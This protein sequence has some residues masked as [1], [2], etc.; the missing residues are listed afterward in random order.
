MGPPPR[1]TRAGGG[2]AGAAGAAARHGRRCGG[3]AA[4]DG[5]VLD[6]A[7][8]WT[9]GGCAGGPMR[10]RASAPFGTRRWSSSRAPRRA[11]SGAVGRQRGRG[12]GPPSSRT[13]RAW[14]ATAVALA[15]ALLP[16]RSQKYP[17]ATCGG[18]W[19]CA[20]NG[21]GG[22]RPTGMR[23]GRVS[24]R[25]P[26][27]QP[28]RRRGGQ[29]GRRPPWQ[30]AWMWRSGGAGHGRWSAPVW[31]TMSLR[32]LRSPRWRPLV[33]AATERHRGAA[34]NRAPG[35][36]CA[37]LMGGLTDGRGGPHPAVHD[38]HPHVGPQTLGGDKRKPFAHVCG[39]P[40]RVGR[41]GPQEAARV[42]PHCRGVF[43]AASPHEPRLA[44]QAARAAL[45]AQPRRRSTVPNPFG[46][47]HPKAD[48]SE[49][50]VIV[51]DHTTD[52]GKPSKL[53][54]PPEDLNAP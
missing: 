13:V 26:A 12:R 38:L 1:A 17:M 49:E 46:N 10:P 14:Q 9:L 6:A 37:C 41:R 15:A 18:V 5:S 32:T 51:A 29:G 21:C 44:M 25:G 22:S 16:W 50:P 48:A 53:I 47:T 35:R 40:V 4:A 39:E 52:N 30:R 43:F 23:R 36:S 7:R 3:P 33:A 24:R 31:A 34:A 54:R 42:P 11:A 8:P 27:V 20:S 19:R 2:C 45:D 28:D